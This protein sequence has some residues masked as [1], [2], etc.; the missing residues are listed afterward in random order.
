MKRLI[1]IFCIV[2]A[3]CFLLTGCSQKQSES[4]NEILSMEN[5][6][7]EAVQNGF[8][9]SYNE[10]LIYLTSINQI[11][12]NDSGEL[13]FT[14][15]NGTT[16][17]AGKVKGNDGIQGQQGN[18]IAS[19]QKSNSD[20]LVDTYTITFTDGTYSSFTVTNGEKGENGAQGQQG[21]GIASI[22]KSNSDGLVDTYTITFTDGTY[23][24]FTVNNGKD[25]LPGKDGVSLGYAHLQWNYT[26]TISTSSNIKLLPTIVTQQNNLVQVSDGNIALKDGY[27]YLIS[28]TASAVSS[29]GYEIISYTDNISDNMNIGTNGGGTFVLSSCSRNYIA[30]GGTTISYEAR[31]NSGFVL[32]NGLSCEIVIIAV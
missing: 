32:P 21:N 20:G 5:A 7:S 10:Y 13:I 18:G 3:V 14:F 23:T 27:N 8:A 31:I 1:K 30:R 15:N 25:G 24:S 17:N 22:Q 9:G 26:E 12:I 16:I 4:P 6:Y 11:I 19:I 28:I 29:N 2:I